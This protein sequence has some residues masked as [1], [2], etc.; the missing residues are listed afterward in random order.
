MDTI[1]EG[2]G[3]LWFEGLAPLRA[4]ISGHSGHG[5]VGEFELAVVQKVRLSFIAQL[6]DIIFV[7]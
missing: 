6:T 7:R 5:T 3:R 4:P 2:R 1:Q